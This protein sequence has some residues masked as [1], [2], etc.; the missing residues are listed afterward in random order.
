ALGGSRDRRPPSLRHGIMLPAGCID[1]ALDGE[2]TPFVLR[3]VYLSWSATLS[4]PALP[5]ASSCGPPLGAPLSPTAPSVSLP[6][7]I[8]TPPWSG[9]TSVNARWPETLVS[10]RCA[11]SSVVPPNVFAV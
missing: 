6:I 8:G 10:V 1:K 5:Q 9:I 7:L 4:I 2:R 11:H 3:L